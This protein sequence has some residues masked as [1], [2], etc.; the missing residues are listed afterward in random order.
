MAGYGFS[1]LRKPYAEWADGVIDVRP[2][3]NW[4]QG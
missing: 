3:Y 2:P 4:T 1:S